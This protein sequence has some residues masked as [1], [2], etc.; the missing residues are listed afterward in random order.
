M[1]SGEAKRNLSAMSIL[2]ILVT[3]TACRKEIA[4]DEAK[5]KP[6]LSVYVV[7]A[8]IDKKGTNSDSEGTAILKGRYDE[9]TKKIDYHIQYANISPQLITL[10]S[11]PKG[12]K[13][14]LVKELYKITE[15][16]ELPS[17]ISGSFFLTPLQ[18]RALLKGLWF[19]TVSARSSSPEISGV[20][21]LKQQK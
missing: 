18:E 11:G 8:R 2:W 5:V 9:E 17:V 21:T 16:Q 12:S 19:A 6:P 13:G 4:A 14:T 3:M 1:T 7:T 20:L 10:R 15:G